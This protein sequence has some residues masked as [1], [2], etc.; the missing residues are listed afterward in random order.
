MAPAEIVQ[1]GGIPFVL[2]IAARLR[3]KP[4]APPPGERKWTNPFLPYEQALWVANLGAR[5]RLLL[6]KFNVVPHHC[7]VVTAEFER[8]EQ[9]LNAADLA[10]AWRT[11][12][13]M[14]RGGLMF[15]NCGPDSGKGG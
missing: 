6:N 13:A 11:M 7:L 8:Q 2:R 5:H 12:Q 4:K 9:D 14:P 10:A 1:D 3:Q 15:F